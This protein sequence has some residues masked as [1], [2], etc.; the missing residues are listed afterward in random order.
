M[1]DPNE[2]SFLKRFYIYQNERFPILAHGFII[3]VFTFS[4]VSYSRICRGK[5]GFIP[6]EIY[7]VGIFATI[8]LFLLVRIFDEF[9]D[10]EEDAKYRKYLP[11][12]RGL[13][14]LNELRVVGI[15]VAVIQ[16]SVIAYFQPSMLLLYAVVLGYLCL[17]GVEFF[18]P[19][20]LK[21]HHMIYIYSH[22]LIIPL[23]DVYASGLDWLLEG[24]EAP[25]GLFFFFA[26]T[27]LNGIVLEFGRKIRTP[28]NEEEGVVSYTGLFGTNRGVIYWIL[29][30][31]ATMLLNIAASIYA[32]YGMVAFVILGVM[33]AI[34]SLPGFLFLSNHTKKLSKLIEY[35]SGLWTLGMYISLGGGPMITKLFFE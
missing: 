10:Q 15:V 25:V 27:Y 7:L 18:V 4:A 24:A 31:F 6:W 14:S 26:V 34:C 17:M 8:S 23:V 1:K 22:M 32:G 19:K 16:I 12:P 11:V 5:E 30:M 9:K 13:I 35:A 33:F 28:D 3:A 2:A 29:L 21:N 20:W